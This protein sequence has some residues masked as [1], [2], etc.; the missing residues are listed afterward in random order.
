MGFWQWKLA[1]MVDEQRVPTKLEVD[2]EIS[3]CKAVDCVAL[4]TGDSGDVGVCGGLSCLLVQSVEWESV[5]RRMNGREK[6]QVIMRSSQAEGDAQEDTFR[7]PTKPPRPGAAGRVGVSR[8][9]RAPLPEPTLKDAVKVTADGA[10][11]FSAKLQ[12]V[13]AGPH[14]VWVSVDGEAIVGSPLT[15]QVRIPPRR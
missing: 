4:V 5:G 3:L 12:W 14:L 6:V 7:T 9:G 15:V 13:H 1:V 10:G 2:A 8:T 11:R